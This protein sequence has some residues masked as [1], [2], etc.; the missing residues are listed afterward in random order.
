MTTRKRYGQFCGLARALDRV[1]DRWTLLLIRELLIA[2]RTFKDLQ[3]GLGGVASNVLV[4]RLRW[5]IQDGLVARNDAPPR[6]RAVT[7]SL[8]EAGSDLQPTIFELIRWGGRWMQSGP[9][10]DQIEPDWSLLAVRALLDGT[11]V[12]R[13]PARTVHVHVGETGL[14]IRLARGRRTVQVSTHGHS[15]AEV[16]MSTPALLAVASGSR[17]L[18]PSVAQVKGSWTDAKAALEPASRR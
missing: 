9:G 11:P 3:V 16:E 4:E 13:G 6:S 5:L 18:D 1:G 2:P 12:P 7:Y 15:D 8:T 10:T 14:T 17:H